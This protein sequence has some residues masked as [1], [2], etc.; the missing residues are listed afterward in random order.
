MVHD[1]SLPARRYFSF[2]LYN[3]RLSWQ[4][5]DSLAVTAWG[6]NLSDEHYYDAG[7]AEATNLGHA[8]KT[9][10]PPRRYGVDVRY[11]F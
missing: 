7:T 10:A 3:A 4:I 1:A 6:K 5:N 2:T 8:I 11:D 9:F